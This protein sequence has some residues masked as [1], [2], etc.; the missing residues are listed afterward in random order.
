MSAFFFLFISKF[1]IICSVEVTK[2][3]IMK[4]NYLNFLCSLAINDEV[5]W[6]NGRT[7]FPLHVRF[8]LINSF[9]KADAIQ[10][11]LFLILTRA[12]GLGINLVDA[13]RVVIFVF[14]LFFSN[15]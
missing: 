6:V 9:N 3:D 8:R 2:R 10:V 7:Y 4:I 13:N 5:K 14:S 11:L 15:K 1:L 12:G